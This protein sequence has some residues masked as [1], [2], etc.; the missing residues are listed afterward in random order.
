MNLRRGRLGFSLVEVMVFISVGSVIF[1]L[2]IQLI[3]LSMIISR[4]AGQQREQDATLSRLTRDFRRDMRQAASVTLVSDSEL[5]AKSKNG[6]SITWHLSDQKL[7]RI[8]QAGQQPV[9]EDYQLGEHYRGNFS[10]DSPAN[11]IQLRV[12]RKSEFAEPM[13]RVERFVE[14]YVAGEIQAS[15]QDSSEALR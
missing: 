4:T 12:S 9:N 8:K 6:P 3:H 2:A 13:S 1:F 11:L 5:L 15:S 10:H 7:R 14:C